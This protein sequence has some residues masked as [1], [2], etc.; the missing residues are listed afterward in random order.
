MAL[1]DADLVVHGAKPVRHLVGRPIV[2]GTE[3]PDPQGDAVLPRVCRAFVAEK[4]S[5]LP[6][7]IPM[8]RPLAAGPGR[9]DRPWI[10]TGTKARD[11]VVVAAVDEVVGERFVQAGEVGGIPIA[12]EEDD[13]LRV[14]LPDRADGPAVNGV[15]QIPVRAVI[16]IDVPGQITEL[17]VHA[18]LV[19][20]V[21]ARDDGI[22]LV[23]GSN[24]P[25]QAKKPVLEMSAVPEEAVP[26]SV[27][28]VPVNVLPSLHGVEIQNSVEI[29][30]FAPPE[31]LAEPLKAGLLVDER[32]IIVFEMSVVERQPHSSHTEALYVSYVC[33][34]EKMI[35]KSLEK[36]LG[37]P[38]PQDFAHLRPERML[39][40]G[41]PI[42]EVFQVHPAADAG[43]PETNAVAL[44]VDDL[45]APYA[46]ELHG[47]APVLHRIGRRVAGALG[48]LPGRVRTV[49]ALG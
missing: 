33:F 16:L 5:L 41:K 6:R 28:R 45:A 47:R 35:E 1:E 10:L 11:R 22:V 25:P 20:Q 12:F 43:T 4:R 8:L 17:V 13:V 26:G 2:G 3:L 15:H 42:D 40:P 29:V 34:V 30:L 19:H 14:G 46:Q 7:Q 44:G 27:I 37:L 32:F 9:N 24:L 36:E 48:R 49:T 21:V 39:C 23:P 18:R 31:H 38:R